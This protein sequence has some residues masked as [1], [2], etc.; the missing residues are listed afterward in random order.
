MRASPIAILALAFMAAHAFAADSDWNLCAF[1]T[2]YDQRIGLYTRSHDYRG[3]TTTQELATTG[4]LATRTMTLHARAYAFIHRADV[5]FC[6]GDY[7]HAIAD[8]D[9]ALKIHSENYLAYDHRG[10]S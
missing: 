2:D 8:N 4:H 3:L 6:N 5:Y 9:E 1:A 10:K 7:D